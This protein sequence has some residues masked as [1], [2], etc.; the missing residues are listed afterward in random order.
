MRYGIAGDGLIEIAVKFDPVSNSISP[1]PRLG[2]RLGL[3]RAFDRVVWYGRG[4]HQTHCDRKL[5]AK[6]GLNERFIGE[7]HP[8]LRPASAQWKSAEVHEKYWVFARPYEYRLWI[9]PV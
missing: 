2:L 3:V 1:M 8:R 7:L 6:I 4:P 9:K 5:G